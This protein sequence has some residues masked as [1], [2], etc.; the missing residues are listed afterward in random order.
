MK[1]KVQFYRSGFLAVILLAA[2]F[3]FHGC[4]KDVLT[5]SDSSRRD[6]QGEYNVSLSSLPNQ[7]ERNFFGLTFFEATNPFVAS[8]VSGRGEHD[9]LIFQMA[10]EM[11]QMNNEQHFASYLMQTYGYPAWSR[12]MVLPSNGSAVPIVFLPLAPIDGDKTTA[13]ISG[14]H[15]NNEWRFQLE[16][17]SRVD[18]LM[19]M[20]SSDTLGLGFR[21]AALASFD[22]DIFG[23]ITPP[24][25]MWISNQDALQGGGFD[26]VISRDLDCFTATITIIITKKFNGEVQDRDTQEPHSF[27]IGYC[28][29]NGEGGGNVFGGGTVGGGGG[30][31]QNNDPNQILD[32]GATPAFNNFWANCQ[33]NMD[34]EIDPSEG[35]LP[36]EQ[37]STCAAL[38]A[39]NS[40]VLLPMSTLEWLYNNPTVIA[41]L[42]N[43]IGQNPISAPTIGQAIAKVVAALKRANTTLNTRQMANLVALQQHFDLTTNQTDFLVEHPEKIDETHSFANSKSFDSNSK[44]VTQLLIDLADQN[45]L[46]IIYDSPVYQ[47]IVSQY[48]ELGEGMGDPTVFV[49]T[50]T[51]A[52][53]LEGARLKFDHPTWSDW[54][55]QLTAAWN[56]STEGIHI[57]LDGI[58]L[59]P[60]A[61]E[62]A[63]L[64][65]GM[66]YTFQGD[67]KNATFSFVAA[68]P[69]V[70]WYVIGTKY[71]EKLSNGVKL[72]WRSTES[73]TVVF[74]SLNSLRRVINTPT[75]EQAHHIIPWGDVN[76]PVIQAAAKKDGLSPWNMN[77]AT[78]GVSLGTARHNGSHDVYNQAVRNKLNEIES[79]FG[80]TNITP[81]MADEKSRFLANKVRE[82]LNQNSDKNLKDPVIINLINAITFQ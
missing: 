39:L 40:T 1:M 38:H 31:G 69:F 18:S 4:K 23:A 42:V 41:P 15:Q 22:K 57:A 62:I 55:I 72:I 34:G 48:P 76:H 20:Y 8:A 64:G 47:Q 24:Y 2:T 19:Q 30:G 28:F 33:D 67:W 26:H 49:A 65:N 78:N 5:N 29:E 58:G 82:I 51:M 68:V 70:G 46:P 75:G 16:P 54:K 27:V 17:R 32:N 53:A 9:T 45:Q 37:M 12:S 10:N 56:V 7:T 36:P 6:W 73:G 71:A 77:E 44:T 63:D 79:Q 61:G 21:V 52:V 35:T 80:G 43:S 14:V 3:S 74:G 50:W 81:E 66:L 11:I 13:Y 25:E 60:A 59:I